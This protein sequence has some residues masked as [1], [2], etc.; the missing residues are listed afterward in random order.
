MLSQLKTQEFGALDIGY[1]PGTS[2]PSFISVTF[3][4]TAPL[5]DDDFNPATLLAAR[6]LRV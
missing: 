6:E 4:A 2:N 3:P 1:K 5:R